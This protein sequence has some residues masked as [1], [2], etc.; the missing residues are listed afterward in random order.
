MSKHKEDGASDVMTVDPGR[1]LLEQYGCG[2]IQFTGSAD[3]LYERHLLFDDVID[4]A[5]RLQVCCAAKPPPHRLRQYTLTPDL[6][7]AAMQSLVFVPGNYATAVARLLRTQEYQQIIDP[8]QQA[9]QAIEFATPLPARRARH[10][11][12]DVDVDVI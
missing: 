4:P 7:G 8:L 1:K 3:G 6:A 12:H 9:L 2:P 5:G 10:Q 11:L